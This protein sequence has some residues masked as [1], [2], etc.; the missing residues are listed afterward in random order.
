MEDDEGVER[1]ETTYFQNLFKTSSPGNPD[2]A[3][4]YITEKVTPEIN[5]S[6][7]RPVSDSEVRKAI[8]E[9]NPEK[10]PVRMV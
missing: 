10:A 9:I 1:V 7:V 8:D 3:L 2:E 5:A 4:R 6:L